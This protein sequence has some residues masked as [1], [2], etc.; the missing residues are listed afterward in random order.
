MARYR[1]V[2]WGFGRIAN[3][4]AFTDYNKKLRLG[5][6]RIWDWHFA[7]IL[8][9]N[10]HTCYYGLQT[11]DYFQSPQPSIWECFGVDRG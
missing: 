7:V 9:V 5:L 2:E 11:S 10:A 4:F 1:I 6:S 8:M 3:L